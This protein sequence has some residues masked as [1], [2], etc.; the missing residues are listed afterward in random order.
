MYVVNLFWKSIKKFFVACFGCLRSSS[1]ALR[2]EATNGGASSGASAKKKVR[3]AAK[4]V[5]A[6]TRAV[7]RNL[8]KGLSNYNILLNPTYKEAFGITWKFAAENKNVRDVRNIRARAHGGAEEDDAAQAD[9]LARR[10]AVSRKK[11]AP[12]PVARNRSFAGSLYGDLNVPSQDNQQS[13]GGALSRTASK[14]AN[15]SGGASGR[16]SDRG[17]VPEALERGRAALTVDT[18]RP[19]PSPSPSATPTPTPT[20]DGG[21]VQAQAVRAS[22]G[23]ST[24]HSGGGRGREGTPTSAPARSPR[25]NSQPAGPP[26]AAYAPAPQPSPHVRHSYGGPPAQVGYEMVPQQAAY[27]P[28]QPPAARS[29][30]SPAQS[31]TAQQYNYQQLQY[32]QQQQQ[33]YYQAQ[34]AA[35]RG[36][37]AGRG[38]RGGSNPTSPH[39]Y[40]QYPDPRYYQGPP[41][42]GQGYGGP[43]Y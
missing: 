37:Q 4:D 42:P 38:G 32:I 22:I 12:K 2:D 34:V 17:V 20:H 41:G 23:G 13:S 21:A 27:Y 35:G 16:N 11:A 10:A 7:Q 30:R 14:E 33:A 36:A 19:T 26:A 3:T 18:T 31:P 29:G 6:Y 40:A 25:P 43:R 15:G 1:Q 24:P 9:E 5:V 39:G 8:I 28:P